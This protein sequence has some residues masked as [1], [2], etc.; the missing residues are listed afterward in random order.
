VQY[1]R[2]HPDHGENVINITNEI[3]FSVRVEEN[4]QNIFTCTSR[5]R[6][7]I[8]VRVSY[9]YV[10]TNEHENEQS[11]VADCEHHGAHC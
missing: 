2:K 4:V 6:H 10:G 5:Q 7:R 3:T 9:I 8:R 11:R 1:R